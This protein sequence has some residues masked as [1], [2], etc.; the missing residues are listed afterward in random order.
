LF[1]KHAPP[2]IIELTDLRLS[3]GDGAEENLVLIRDAF[4]VLNE[5]DNNIQY[6]FT[7]IDSKG[8]NAYKFIFYLFSQSLRQRRKMWSNDTV[9]IRPF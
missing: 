3:I 1:N 4:A 7:D 5:K 9:H 8:Q 6:R 2:I